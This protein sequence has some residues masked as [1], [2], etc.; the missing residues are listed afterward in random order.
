ME[1]RLRSWFDYQR[2]E[3]EPRLKAMLDDALGRYDFSD[4][5]E[6]PDDAVDGL[7]AAGMFNAAVKPDKEKRS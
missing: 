7:N 4:E 1:N 6:L 2:F 5:G 3:N